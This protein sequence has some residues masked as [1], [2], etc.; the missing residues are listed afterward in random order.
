MGPQVS[1]FGG[2]HSP[3]STP[4]RTIQTADGAGVWLACLQRVRSQG[5][6]RLDRNWGEQP[7]TVP[8]GF[9]WS[10]VWA[11]GVGRDSEVLGAGDGPGHQT[12]GSYLSHTLCNS[13]LPLVRLQAGL[14]FSLH[15]QEIEFKK[16]KKKFIKGFGKYSAFDS[17]SQ[18]AAPAERQ[19]G[20]AA[21]G[22]QASRLLLQQRD[23]GAGTPGREERL[24][25]RRWRASCLGAC[26]QKSSCFAHSTSPGSTRCVQNGPPS[27][28]SN[29]CSSCGGCVV[30]LPR[31]SHNPARFHPKGLL[32]PPPRPVS[33]RVKARN[34][35][36][37]P[38]WGHEEARPSPESPHQRGGLLAVTPINNPAVGEGGKPLG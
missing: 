13:V 5:H 3:P 32:R 1:L 19:K 7:R 18:P 38:V 10:L 12:M 35:V 15:L 6:W 34:G 33:D 31:P 17:T 2:E 8:P 14:E 37:D 23:R 20:P 24:A 26:R 16:K 30:S 22:R 28:G 29:F 27:S 36:N 4:H 11:G 25:W 21:R 9:H